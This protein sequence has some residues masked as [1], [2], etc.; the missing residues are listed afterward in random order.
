MKYFGD[1]AHHFLIWSFFG[2]DAS[3]TELYLNQNKI[4]GAKAELSAVAAA[5][6]SLTI[7]GV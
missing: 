4:G 1:S 2:Q 3:L 7:Y 5:R 6:P